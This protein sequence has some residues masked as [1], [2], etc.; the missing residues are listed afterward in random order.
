VAGRRI[1]TDRPL[2]ELA[3]FA[4]CD[5]SGAPGLAT[6]ADDP[7]VPAAGPR[8]EGEAVYSGPAW[9]GNRM[10]ATA[11]T[12][13]PAGFDLEI[14]GAGRFFVAADGRG[15]AVLA[16]APGAPDALLVEVALGPLLILVL[17]L[18]GVFASA[19]AL[20]AG[21]APPRALAFLG[22]S[23]SGKSTLAAGLACSESGLRRLADDV[24]PLRVR[25]GDLQVRPRFPQLKLPADRQPAAGAPEGLPLAGLFLLAPSEDSRAGR[26][27]VG[28][29]ELSS[30]DAALALVR[31]TAAARLFAPD[32]LERHL[33]A[34]AIVAGRLPVRR[35]TYPW[36]GRPVPGL[37]EALVAG[38]EG[39]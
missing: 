30:R 16:P 32:L 37:A 6:L 39:T 33:G 12:F 27:E 8:R 9:I 22:P 28:L 20:E 10:R 13:S 7:R 35:L 24:L 23:G 31:Y 15:A 38:L 19:V 26:G 18:G 14:E 17:A 2:E 25:E 29:E 1:E 3:A 5:S 34:A 11:C 4:V 21:D 36:L